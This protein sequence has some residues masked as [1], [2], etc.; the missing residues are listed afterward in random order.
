MKKQCRSC[1]EYRRCKDSF[2]SWIFFIVGLIA[3]IAMRVVTVL[4]H[5]DP[6]YGKIAWYIGIGGF[7]FFFIYKF[8]VSQTRAKLINQ[9]DL[10]NKIARK[11]KLSEDDYTLMSSLLCAL[12]SRKERINYFFIFGLSAVALLLAIYIDFIK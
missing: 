8:H 2:T 3:T 6:I 9:H 11:S 5:I 12:S 10:E 7:L 1:S 4:M